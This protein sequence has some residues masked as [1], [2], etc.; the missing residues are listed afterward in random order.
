MKAARELIINWRQ[1]SVVITLYALLLVSLYAL[2]TTREATKMQVGVTLALVFAVPVLF[3]ALQSTGAAIATSKSVRALVVDSVKTGWKLI[4][5]SIPLVATV[6]LTLYLLH[7]LQTRLGIAVPIAVP[8]PA[9]QFGSVSPQMNP[10]PVQFSAVAIS[11]LRYLVLGVLG[12]VALI[13]L[14]I[15]TVRNGLIAT[16]R[17]VHTHLIQAIGAQSL[18]IYM[19]GF[20]IFAVAPYLLLFKATSASR[21]WVEIG[22]LSL[23]LL[24]VFL[25][26]LLGW[27][28]TVRA[29]SLST[30]STALV[31]ETSDAN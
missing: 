1:L 24:A 30:E 11:T 3:F 31:P 16:L 18:L 2:I 5:V 9:A 6:A 20:V 29:L 23:R 27:L 4:V 22:L 8:D 10:R 12:P 7:K 19:V 21:A 28:L 17:G 25:M 13:H 14:W 26:T 15:S